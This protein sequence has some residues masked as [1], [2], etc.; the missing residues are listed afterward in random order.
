[1][2]IQIGGGGPGGRS[3]GVH[4]GGGGGRPGD[5]HQ[6]PQ[7]EGGPGMGAPHEAGCSIQINMEQCLSVCLCV[8]FKINIKEKFRYVTVFGRL[9]LQ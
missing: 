3:D 2:L 1:M 5:K 9:T 8:D 7:R 6:L 4:G